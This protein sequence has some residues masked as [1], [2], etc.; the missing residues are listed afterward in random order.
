[1]AMQ[2]CVQFNP[3]AESVDEF[4]ERFKVQCSDV[5]EKADGDDLKKAAVLVKALPV[6]IIT[7][8]QRRIKPVKLS[9]ATYQELESKLIT[10]YGTK[11]SIV[12]ATVKFLNRKQSP[13]ETIENYAKVLNDL[14]SSC[15]YE[16]CCRDRMLR[17]AFVSGLRSGAIVT[18]LLPDCERKT[19]NECV[20]KAKFLEQLS[21]D[22]QDI[23]FEPK[24]HS[25]YKLV[26]SSDE[27]VSKSKIPASYICIRCGSKAKHRASQCYAKN[28]KCNKCSK[29]GHLGKVCK[30]AKYRSHAVFDE[31]QFNREQADVELQHTSS[32][33]QSA[34]C[35][36]TS[37]LTSATQ[38]GHS[39]W[40][41]SNSRDT[42]QHA[43]WGGVRAN[44]NG[45]DDQC[46]SFLG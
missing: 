3:N 43:G 22:A 27:S 12:G 15:N 39:R 36:T 34:T 44:C 25:N 32:V 13:G 4:I 14:A 2:N 24:M 5:L 20:E 31:E 40:P 41:C 21:S 9:A 19:F 26:S 11:K 23:Q 45:C 29:I 18:G 8:L 16:N 1:M 35:S 6:N 46:D 28:M 7:D 30:S 17:D 10:Q 37:H 33:N 38:D 42:C